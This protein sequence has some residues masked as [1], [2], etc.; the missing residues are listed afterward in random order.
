MSQQLLQEEHITPRSALHHRPIHPGVSTDAAPLV[1]R[2]SRGASPSR[3]T[4][5]TRSPLP[6]PQPGSHR[7]PRRD[8]LFYVGI[9]MLLALM[10]VVLGH[11]LSRGPPSPGMICIMDGHALTRSMPLWA[12]KPRTCLVT[13]LH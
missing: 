8:F 9:G 1:P 3:K 11:L 12:M 6:S 2:A 5:Q 4:K 13:S 10:L 7:R